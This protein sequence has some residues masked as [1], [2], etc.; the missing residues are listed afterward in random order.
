MYHLPREV[1][2]KVAKVL[3]PL[4]FAYLMH[5]LM[6]H[7][8]HS[9]PTTP[10][11]SNININGDDMTAVLPITNNDLTEAM[12]QLPNPLPYLSV[13]LT[14][15]MK[16]LFWT[17]VNAVATVAFGGL[18]WFGLHLWRARWLVAVHWRARNIISIVSLFPSLPLPDGSR[19]S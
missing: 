16:N 8:M 15:M 12:A 5:S 6:L 9:D 1:P 7:H 2:I 3:A 10:I 19:S 18:I 4:Y 17:I 11:D 13:M 14:V